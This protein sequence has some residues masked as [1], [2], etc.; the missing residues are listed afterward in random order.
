MH[1]ETTETTHQAALA[2]QY[3]NST[4]RHIFLTGKAGTGKTTFLRDIGRRTQKNFVIVAPTGIAALNA[5]GT[6]IHSQFL[7]PFGMYLPANESLPQNTS[8]PAFNNYSM[9]RRSMDKRRK[10]VLSKLEL[11]IID[12]VSMLRSDILDAIDNR[13]RSATRRYKL[14]FG[15]VQLLMIGDLYQLPPVVKQDEMS[16]MQK[17]YRSAH[18][19]ESRALQEK[20][21]VYIE[22]NKIFRQS[23]ESFIRILNHLREDCCTPED[24]QELNKMVVKDDNQNDGRII[25][26]THNQRA[27]EINEQSLK[28]LKGESYFYEAEIEGDFPENMNPIKPALELKVGAQVMFIKNDPVEKRFFNGK[29]AEVVELE[30]DKIWVLP[31]DED[32]P[33]EVEIHEW[34][35]IRYEVDSGSKEIKEEVL[36]TFKHY[37]L[38]LAWA[39]TVHKS[40]GLTF[41]RA[42]IDVSRAFAPGQVYVALSRLRSLEGLALSQPLGNNVIQ[43]DGKVL[44]YSEQ[45]KNQPKEGDTLRAWQMDYLQKRL[46]E[47]FDL[48]SLTKSVFY[49]IKDTEAKTEFEDPQMRSALP[50]IKQRIEAEVENGEKFQRQLLRL[51]QERQ[52]HK[53]QERLAKG[54]SYF[55]KM[56]WEAEYE[57]LL[58]WEEVKLFSQTKQIQNKLEELELQIMQYVELIERVNHLVTYIENGTE[59]TNED[60]WRPALKKK[61]SELLQKAQQKARERDIASGSK[62]TGRKRK[63]QAKGE[64]YEKS[65]AMLAEGK[66][67]EEIAKERE[68]A[69]STIEGHCVRGINEGKVDIFK[70][71]P[72]KAIAEITVKY[73]EHPESNTG[74]IRSHLKDQYSYNQIKMVR[75]HLDKMDEK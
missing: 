41:D 36:G 46:Q 31:Q 60:S 25:L 33:L 48:R 27:R 18:F 72:K 35:N 29:L 71:L 30:E 3:V 22:L 34:K 16:L 10:A 47:A 58:H 45:Q 51:L 43:C 11:L 63:K 74:E 28:A 52:N 62:K 61:R 23:D 57:L 75:A 49:A 64:T 26:T 70:I 67:I 37:P 73:T 2:A 6:T 19:F 4:D 44:Q 66:T 39:I 59:Q 65:F 5:G 55:L 32:T 38:R 56:L 9:A 20:P 13:L 53:L 24:L 12:E 8:V 15:G 21:P 68:L 7:L 14:P 50:Q 42:K 69:T 40:Q 1:T 54:Q 17:Y